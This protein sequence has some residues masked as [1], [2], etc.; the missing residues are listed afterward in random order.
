VVVVDPAAAPRWNCRGSRACNF[1]RRRRR[2]NSAG[3]SAP[4][5]IRDGKL[6]SANL[7]QVHAGEQALRSGDVV[8][9]RR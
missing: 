3:V 6:L 4:P 7:K 8:E 5:D 2:G 1:T 9:L